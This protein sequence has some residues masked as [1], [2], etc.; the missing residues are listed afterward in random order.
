MTVDSDKLARLE[1]HPLFQRLM[2]QPWEFD[3]FRAV[4]LLERS[5]G[6]CMPVGG[7]GPVSR[8]LI[9]FRPHVTVS[10]PSTDIR[11]IKALPVDLSSLP[12]FRAEVT[13]LG[14]YGVSSPL[15]VHYAVQMFR[16]SEVQEGD[17]PVSSK[18]TESPR[19]K[20]GDG[21]K[22][23]GIAAGRSLA[24]QSR[25]ASADAARDFLDLFNH[26]LISFYY[27]AWT[28][29]RYDMS[30]GMRERDVLT[31]YLLWLIGVSVDADVAALGVPPL[32][33]LR[34][35]GILTQHPRSAV[36]L[37]G[38][39]SD[40]WEGMLPIRVDQHVGRWVPVPFEDLNTMGLANCRLGEDMI[41]GERVYD[42]SGAFNVQI[43]PV[44]WQTYQWFLPDGDAHAQTR[45]LVKFFAADPLSYTIEIRLK[46]GEVPE[47]RLSS[48]G[49]SGRLGLTSWVRT[50]DVPE[51][52]VSFTEL[53]CAASR[54]GAQRGTPSA[55]R[56]TQTSHADGSGAADRVHVT[57]GAGRRVG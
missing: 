42:L 36:S 23:D 2:Q 25:Q 6:D 29:Y 54:F 20:D 22:S 46:A 5:F 56:S 33:L 21:A 28:K 13:F 50:K 38:I 12:V 51:T 39:L 57:P 19:S 45:A 8:E 9:R 4:W 15:P 49:T 52:S 10:F 55:A 18:E 43:G 27:R 17:I 44:D 40:Y 41:A 14:L 35:A 1:S 53:S 16:T 3:F 47:T 32:R 37:E 31:R 26:R 7:R 48:D 11:R 34:Y 30:F 24:D